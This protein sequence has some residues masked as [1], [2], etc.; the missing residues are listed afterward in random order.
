MVY[1]EI[2]CGRNVNARGN[3]PYLGGTNAVSAVNLTCR[4]SIHMMPSI[5][6]LCVSWRE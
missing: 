1:H 2:D 4:R 5:M 3:T 6:D